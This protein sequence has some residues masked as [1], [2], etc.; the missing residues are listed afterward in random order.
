VQCGRHRSS[1]PDANFDPME[2]MK[3]YRYIMHLSEFPQK[4]L[5]RFEATSGLLYQV[6]QDVFADWP[7]FNL[8]DL[9]RRFALVLAAWPQL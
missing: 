3:K 8:N 7:R 5:E 9:Q 2:F 4:E 1:D 6:R